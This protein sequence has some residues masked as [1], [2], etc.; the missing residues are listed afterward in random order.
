MRGLLAVVTATAVSACSIG[1]KAPS[2]DWDGTT[3]PDCTDDNSLA[4]GDG[5]LGGLMIGVGAVGAQVS[6]QDNDEG[7]PSTAADAVALVGLLGGL[8]FVISYFVGESKYKQCHDAM[9]EWHVGRNIG[10]AARAT[11]DDDTKS[12]REKA[13]QEARA[14]EKAKP[15]VIAPRGFFCASSPSNADAG[16]CVREKDECQRARDAALAGVADLSECALTERAFC[17]GDRC[18]P[19]NEACA[20]M[21]ARV[22]GPDGTADECA[23][24]E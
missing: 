12:A 13:W 24:S 11:S 16:L 8:V 22:V 21:R 19:T 15:P 1:I 6:V 20:A 23:D 18:A 3:K 17:F 5:I 4:I 10:H 2:P 9:A 14:K 7:H